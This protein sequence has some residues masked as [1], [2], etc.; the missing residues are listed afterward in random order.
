[1]RSADLISLL[2]S[3]E[4]LL[5]NIDDAISE[6][7]DAIYSVRNEADGLDEDESVTYSEKNLETINASSSNISAMALEFAEKIKLLLS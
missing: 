5:N 4:S 2:D 6:G 1:M 3:M 7:L